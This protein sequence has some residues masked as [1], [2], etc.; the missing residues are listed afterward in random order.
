[1]GYK[2]KTTS[3]QTIQ[4]IKIMKTKITLL[5]ILS[6]YVS[7]VN[8]QWHNTSGLP[9]NVDIISMAKSGSNIFAGTSKGVYLSID[10]GN[11]WSAVNS[12]L[13]NTFVLAL[14]TNGDKIYAGTKGGGVFLSSNNGT[15]W[16][17]VNNGIK[18]SLISSLA[19][20]G[21]NIFAG[22]SSNGVYL[23]NNNGNIWTA[24]NTDLT[25]QFTFSLVTLGDKIFV[26]T[27]GGVFSSSNNG[28]NW[29]SINTGLP[30]ISN[31]I[32]KL[33]VS[34]T[35]ILALAFGDDLYKLQNNEFSW[36]KM[37]TGLSDISGFSA[38][39]NDI[40]I[41]T[42]Y[43]GMN[44]SFD[45]GENW[46]FD[47]IGIS[48]HYVTNCFS[49]DSINTFIESI[50]QLYKRGFK[51]VTSVNETN[52]SNLK[53]YPNPTNDRITIDQNSNQFK[54]L[55]ISIINMQGQTIINQSLKQDKTTLGISNL[56]N[57]FYLLK[58]SNG[59]FVEIKK[60]LKE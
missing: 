19:I 4:K 16:S 22:T 41:G 35:N 38:S 47:T 53:I 49:F 52:Y 13:T 57:G 11:N 36:S 37:N 26:A 44:S 31:Q 46:K 21:N 10:E 27:Y 58:L 59:Q 25:N 30:Y 17:A 29:S 39:E 45:Q 56:K 50:G 1:M 12:G 20:I 40:Y 23:S 3:V 43:S 34:G 51:E 6:F 15:N 18:D 5:I 55:E 8:A 48:T 60:I 7:F 32:S 24:V 14:A 28:S 54:N 33:A 2:K 9:L 42:I